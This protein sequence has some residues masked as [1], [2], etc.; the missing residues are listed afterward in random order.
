MNGS[1]VT[2][3][4]SQRGDPWILANPDGSP[5]LPIT[6][7]PLNDDGWPMQPALSQIFMSGYERPTRLTGPLNNQTDRLILEYSI[8]TG[9]WNV[10]GNEVF[11]VGRND[12]SVVNTL[13]QILPPAVNKVRRFY[14]EDFE[15]ELFIFVKRLSAVD[16]QDQ[17]PANN[18][19]NLKLRL[20]TD[21]AHEDAYLADP[22]ELFF[23][24]Y[25]AR[26]QELNPGFIRTGPNWS[27]NNFSCPP[28][29]PPPPMGW[30]P[31]WA[32]RT[33]LTSPR[34]SAFEG[35]PWELHARLANELFADLWICIPYGA[36]QTY[37]RELAKLI[38]DELDPDLQCFVEFSNEMWNSG[39]TTFNSL[40]AQAEI[41]IPGGTPAQILAEMQRLAAEAAED[42]FI[43]WLTEWNDCRV[44]LVV[45]GDPKDPIWADRIV[46]ELADT[47]AGSDH[48]GVKL[49]D[50][51]GCPMYFKPLAADINDWTNGVNLPTPPDYPEVKT[52]ILAS[53]DG[54][55]NPSTGMSGNTW[56]LRKH[57]EIADTY[58]LQVFV[59]EGGPSLIGGGASLGP[60]YAD[61]QNGLLMKDCLNDILF[62]AFYPNLETLPL[63]PIPV[64]ASKLGYFAF[65]QSKDLLNG[66][67]LLL[68]DLWAGLGP[69]SFDPSF[70]DKFD[71]VKQ[72]NLDH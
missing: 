21:K 17:N 72:F 6:M 15:G 58:D 69:A 42:A 57:S 41:N 59:Y 19:V 5:V 35:V 32:A 39:F 28:G 43:W 12:P 49:V 70:Q 62:K 40:K 60:I 20:W 54:D 14:K 45:M 53:I 27:R 2:A 64:P 1:I 4:L 68:T 33:Q 47:S 11:V 46:Q 13:V 26:L 67:F 16:N 34:Y 24:Q 22:K 44:K 37:V 48:P 30:F 61:F 65:C 29:M 3:D 25:L 50:A 36:D 18:A 7:A 23:G 8:G 31:N 56:F 55:A 38:R 51:V 66:D 63:G 10:D 71:A 52:S 9:T